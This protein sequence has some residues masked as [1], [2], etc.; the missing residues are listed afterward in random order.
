V[1]KFL[2]KKVNLSSELSRLWE[3]EISKIFC[4]E[5]NLR[6]FHPLF[7]SCNE[8]VCNVRT[9]GYYDRKNRSEVVLGGTE[10]GDV[11]GLETVK[12][13]PEQ[14]QE[15]IRQISHVQQ[16]RHK[17]QQPHHQEQTT[18]QQSLSCTEWCCDCEK[19]AFIFLLLSAWLPPKGMKGMLKNKEYTV[20]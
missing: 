16:I 7:L 17:K 12:R 1:H 19:C 20:I 14:E 5:E 3:L 2:T 8:P 11:E 13:K 15:Q 4:Q 10:E 6:K 9:K 18:Q